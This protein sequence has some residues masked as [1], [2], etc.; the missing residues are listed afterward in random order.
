MWNDPGSPWHAQTGGR[1]LCAYRFL[2]GVREGGGGG[3][4][5]RMDIICETLCWASKKC[6]IRYFPPPIQSGRGLVTVLGGCR[7][8]ASRTMV[9]RQR[10]LCALCEGGG[11]GGGWVCSTGVVHSAQTRSRVFSGYVYIRKTGVWGGGATFSLN[12][13]C[14]CGN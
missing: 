13:S 1:L 8:A 10:A 2:Y 11:E 14:E 9:G 3:K 6:P 12:I 7:H 4:R 5:Q